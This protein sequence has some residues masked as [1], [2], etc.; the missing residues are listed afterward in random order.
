MT[1]NAPGAEPELSRAEQILRAR[2]ARV[3]VWALITRLAALGIA[4]GLSVLQL[5]GVIPLGVIA[6]SELE[7]IAVIVLAGTIGGMVW[8]GLTLARRKLRLS[9]VGLGVIV[10][11]TIYLAALPTLWWLNIPEGSPSPAPIVKGGLFGVGLLLI[12]INSIALRPLYPALMTLSVFAVHAVLVVLIFNGPGLTITS[13]YYEHA[14]SPA[15]NPGV[16]VIQA[17]I[18]LFVGTSLTLLAR[19][20]RRTI[21]DAVD[22]EV[23]NFE[24]KER[25]AEMIMESKMSAVRG[26]VAGVAH[27]M[28]NPAGVIRSSVDTVEK[29]AHKLNEQVGASDVNSSRVS[30]LLGL[31]SESGASARQAL[32]RI[33]GLVRSLRDFAQLDGAELQRIDL[34]KSL[35]GALALVPSET[36]GRVEVIR[37]YGDIPAIVCRPQEL[38]QVFYTLLKN[39]FEAMAGQGTLR[40]RTETEGPNVRVEV[41]D[42][43]PGIHPEKLATL[44][45]LGFSSEKGRVAMGMGLPVAQQIVD[46]HGGSLTASSRLGE[47]ATLTI[48]LPVGTLEPTRT[49]R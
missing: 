21:Q 39:A 20:A 49:I 7:A 19:A 28:N 22:L 18:L 47:G 13:S 15:L 4:V 23:A 36:R 11:D 14:N 17:I 6:E 41:T 1:D 27:E 33:S 34:G 45:E 8:Y 42:S 46:R 43:G 24:I 2:E 3:L 31:L 16:L 12:V 10:S 44:F 35:D 40:L 29:C 32:D 30:Q 25:Q 38:N 37:E 9:Q 26:L 48:S 5:W